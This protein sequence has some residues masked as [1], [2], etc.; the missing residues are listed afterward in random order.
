MSLS[1]KEYITCL[2]IKKEEAHNKQWLYIDISAKE[3][4]KE[5][6]SRGG[7]QN[8]CCEAMMDAMLEGD[9]FIV[10]PK[11]KSRSDA[12]LRI[13]YYVDNLHPQRKKYKDIHK[14]I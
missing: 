6:E 4:A 1:I 12:N 10:E 3:L 9:Y 13:R 8:A 5:C 7:N 11:M 14:K 2:Q